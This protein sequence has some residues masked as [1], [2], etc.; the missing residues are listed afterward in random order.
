MHTKCTNRGCFL[1]ETYINETAKTAHGGLTTTFERQARAIAGAGYAP[2][3]RGATLGDLISKYADDLVRAPWRTKLRRPSGSMGKRLRR[4]RTG[5]IA[6]AGCQEPM[7][8]R[9]SDTS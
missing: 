8:P 4:C 5:S 3:P 6:D 1:H 7:M 9:C 2:P